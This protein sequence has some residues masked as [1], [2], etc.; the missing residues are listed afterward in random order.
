MIFVRQQFTAFG[1]G[2]LILDRLISSLVAR[3]VSVSLLCRS[4]RGRPDIEFIRCDPPRFPRFARDRRFGRAACRLLPEKRGVLVQSH[5]RMSCCDIF[6]AGDGVHAAYLEWRTREA[7]TLGRLKF[8]LH[9]FHRAILAL[10]REMFATSRLRGVLANSPMVAE[11][12]VRH[13]GYPRKRIHLVPNGIDLQHFSPTLRDRHRA[14]V[15]R[16]LG[17]DPSRP[18]ALFVG[19]GYRRKGLNA[20]IRAMAASGSAAELWVV[21]ADSR[22]LAY[23]AIAATAGIGARLKLIG[24]VA[25]PTPYYG[26]A[27]LLLLPSVYD[28][29]P[30]AVIE[31]MAS[32]L[33]V[34]TSNSCGARE[35]AA[36]LDNML[37][38]D[39]DDTSGLAEALRHAFD[40]A[41]RASTIDAAR[42]IASDY[43]IDRMID[44]LLAAYAEVE[45]EVGA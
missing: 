30:S 27:D 14:A 1:G 19:S 23:R 33:P 32:G 15:R 24:P 28:P 16:Q 13:F 39:A 5:E 20:A 17:T 6:R 34:V 4:W 11:E 38:R 9:P 12:I 40:L 44:R 43:G 31:A 42:A 8:A 41:A 2:E 18:V 21:G 36:R 10:E 35:V 37:V 29:F 7:G 22:P 26:A 3:G 25:D 45:A